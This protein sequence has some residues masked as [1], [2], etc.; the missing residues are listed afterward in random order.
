MCT[1]KQLHK[2]MHTHG[3][4]TFQLR[5][6]VYDDDTLNDD[7]VD[8]VFAQPVP[9]TNTTTPLL[10]TGL[11]RISQIK[12]SFSVKCSENYYGPECLTFCEP[13]NDTLGH[14]T[15][16][17]DGSIQCLPN[18]FATNCTE[19]CI[20][21]EG[22]YG[23][24]PEDGSRFCLENYFGEDCKVFCVARNDDLGHYSCNKETGG[25]EC[26][27]GYREP[28]S[29]CTECEFSDLFWYHSVLERH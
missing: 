14:F 5:I 3:Q 7:F 25:R 17:Q 6:D 22:R 15:C 1:Y 20:P 24:N 13:R 12:L 29:N 18:Y 9:F 28:A 21:I 8:E 10:Y 19:F 23:C 4:G 26:L 27:L 11:D 2:N 16:N